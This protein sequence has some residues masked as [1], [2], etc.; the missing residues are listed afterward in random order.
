MM[1]LSGSGKST[2]LRAANGLDRRSRAGSVLIDDK[3]GA[4][5]RRA[6]AARRACGTC[7]ASA[8]RWCS[9]SSGCCPG[10][11]SRTTSASGWSC[12]ARPPASGAE[13]VARAA[14]AG[15]P[16][17]VGGPRRRRT[18]RRHAAARRP[19]ARLCDQRRHPADG[20]AVLGARPADPRQ[21]AGRTAGAAGAREEDDPVRQPRPRRGA[22]ARRPHLDHASRPHRADRQRA[23]HRA[24]P[25]GRLRRGVR[26]AHEPAHGADRRDDHAQARADGPGGRRP[27]P[28]RGATLSIAA[29][30]AGMCRSSCASTGSRI[31]LCVVGDDAACA[32][33]ERA[34]VVAPSTLS[35]Q[36]PDQPAPAEP[37]IR[38]CWPRAAGCSASAGR[39]KSS[40]RCRRVTPRG[41]PHDETDSRRLCARPGLRL[42]TGSRNRRESRG[43]RR[44]RSARP[45]R[46]ARAAPGEHAGVHF[47]MRSSSAS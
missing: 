4:D 28:G 46:R 2:L 44:V 3:D 45:P 43:A 39:R 1:G 36:A 5:R 22:A 47:V 11:R 12:A 42:W 7:G 18:L 26:A 29:R 23:G 37:A 8:S 17:A 41:R 24:A 32:E 16:H 14:R 13:I 19:R 20:R 40:A 31:R 9:S 35:L 30:T 27:V 25:G 38:C 34:V 6:A 10:A 21:A 33:D 15:R